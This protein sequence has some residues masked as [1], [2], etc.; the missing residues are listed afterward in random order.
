[1]LLDLGLEFFLEAPPHPLA[2]FDLD[3]QFQLPQRF[4]GAFIRVHL[5]DLSFWFIS[6]GGG[7][8]LSRHHYGGGVK[9]RPFMARFKVSN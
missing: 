7:T 5:F 8:D 1:V 3:F 2:A 9:L 4:A 6:L